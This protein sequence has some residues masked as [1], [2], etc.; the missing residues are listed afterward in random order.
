MIQAVRRNSK[1]EGD[2]S[3][4][5]VILMCA[6]FSLGLCPAAFAAQSSI[7]EA[8][9]YSCMGVDKSRKQAEQEA[10]ADAKRNAVEGAKTHVKSQTTV[11]DLQIERDLIDA[12]AQA[13][14][15]VI[16]E[17]ARDWYRDAVSGDCCKIRIQAE[18]IPEAE[19]M[20][21]IG[22]EKGGFTDPAAPL[23]VKVWTDRKTYRQGERIKIY[24]QGNKPSYARIL[25]KDAGGNLLQLLPNAHRR[26][27]YFNGGVIYELPA[28]NDRFELEVSP[29]FGMEQVLVYAG[30]APPGDLDVKEMGEGAGGVYQVQT[31]GAE[32]GLKTRGIKIMG[33]EPGA[34]PN[35]PTTTE[36]V[37]SSV[38]ITTGGR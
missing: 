30:T 10:L 32:I 37:E 4:L 5:S 33:K 16:R 27:N 35:V 25:Y 31:R 11:K 22:Q 20:I 2:M 9:G 12:Y 34:A 19:A 3:R 36:F 23:N 6:V 29:P 26:D 38:G 17:L 7:I 1:E 24:L 13:S 28:G 14:V 18:V 15:R 8:E 21:R